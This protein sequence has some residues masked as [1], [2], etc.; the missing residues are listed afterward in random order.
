VI[1]LRPDSE[2]LAD[3]AAGWRSAYIHLPFCARRCPYCDF[4]V[5]TP[6]EGGDATT[7]ARYVDAVLAEIEM[8]AM[9]GP[10]DAL[11]LGGGTPSQLSATDLARLVQAVDERFGLAKGAE[12]SI[13]VN[14]EDWSDPVAESLLDVG[15][16]RVSFGV[17]SFDA[18]VLADLGRIHT[19]A[20]ARDAVASARKAGFPSINLDLIFGTPGESAA[21]WRSTVEAALELEPHHLSMYALTVELGTALSRAVRAGAPAPDAD[22]QAEKYEVGFALADAAGLV[23]YEVSNAARAGHACRYNLATWAQGEYLGF[24]LGAHG[25]RNG[26]RR[27]NLR[28]L[29]AYL[30]AVKRSAPPEAGREEL[31]PFA[32][33]Q[34]RVLVGL[35]RTAGVEA[36][37]AGC[38]LLASPEGGRLIDAGVIAGR[39]DRIVVTAPL[40]TDAAGRAVLS[41]S[42][43]DC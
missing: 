42:A 16:N 22:D 10:L 29:D 23:R 38:R 14:P 30:A 19:A 4:A 37:L 8:E 2:Q 41:L 20:V 21:S 25:H 43:G 32:R 27:R 33:D 35:R 18:A 11:N 39:G 24:G 5:V 36:G 13:E 1:E 31:D 9:W 6:D 34:E 26:V 3:R 12:V 17:Q 7:V 40:L 15:F 28:R